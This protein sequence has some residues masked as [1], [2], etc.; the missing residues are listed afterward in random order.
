VAQVILELVAW[1]GQEHPV[2]FGPPRRDQAI[3]KSFDLQ[4]IQLGG[5]AEQSSLEFALLAQQHGR[6][7]H[8][9]EQQ[10]RRKQFVPD[11]Q[12]HGARVLPDGVAV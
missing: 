5:V 3:G 7:G 6:Q 4:A 10:K 1:P 2:A 12:C 9:G 11:S 8:A